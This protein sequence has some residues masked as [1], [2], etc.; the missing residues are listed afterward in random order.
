MNT[1]E[2]ATSPWH[3]LVVDDDELVLEVASLS[4]RSVGGFS[5][6]TAV[7]G[8]HAVEACRVRLPDVVL[9]DM[10]MPGMDG[11]ETARAIAQLPGAAGLPIVVLTAKG[12]AVRDGVGDAPVLAVLEKPFDPMTL[13]DRLR[14]V[15]LRA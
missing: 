12:E 9:L 7:D 10:M 2:G 15:L 4:L 8:A 14:D 6:E 1:I 5:V 13:P 3:V 11:A